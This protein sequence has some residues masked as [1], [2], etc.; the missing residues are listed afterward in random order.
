MWFEHTRVFKRSHHKRMYVC[1]RMFLWMRRDTLAGCVATWYSNAAALRRLRHLVCRM[2]H[3]IAVKAFRSWFLHAAVPRAVRQFV[4][5]KAEA[6]LAQTFLVWCDNA[7][8]Q[9]QHKK[10]L[11]SSRLWSGRRRSRSC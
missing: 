10:R 3:V 4:L 9:L 5:R 6:T 1:A 7:A 8:G 11:A 2:R